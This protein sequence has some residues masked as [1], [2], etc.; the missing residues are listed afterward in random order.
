FGGV[1]SLTASQTWSLG[2]NRINVN[3]AIN[4][5]GNTLNISA[6]DA[7]SGILNFNSTT[8]LDSNVTIGTMDKVYSQGFSV[9]F[10]G[11]NNTNTSFSVFGGTANIASMGN[12]TGAS[13]IGKNSAYV[14]STSTLNYTGA[15]ATSDKG[16]TRDTNGGTTATDTSINVITA[17]ETLTMS[18]NLTPTTAFPTTVGGWK[19]GG[20]GNLALS[21]NI[22]NG[23]STTVTKIGAGTLTLSG[24][25]TYTGGTTVSAGTLQVGTADAGSTGPGTVQ[26]QSGATLLGTGTVQTGAF[27]AASGAAIQ[28]GDGTGTGDFGTLS[29][30]TTSGS[31]N[32][33][34]QSGSNTTLGLKPAGSG[35]TLSFNGSSAGTLNFNGNLAV[36][37]PGYTPAGV[38]VFNLLDWTNISTTVFDSRY[39]AA[40]YGGLLLGNGDDGLGFDLPD[41]SGSGYGWDIS[42]FTTDGTIATVAIPEP[43][44]AALLLLGLASLLPR[45]RPARG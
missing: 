37:A 25:N 21:G 45:R 3:G 29:F 30:I 39:N 7:A 17:G 15:T 24:T 19:F 36:T 38:E 23:T 8:T 31:G 35:D 40:S 18:G 5:A 44:E 26:V 14:R 33:D 4:T 6:K 41:I 34:L 28:A 11:T 42:K 13:S 12:L 20:A 10:N 32:F 27:T 9:T 43:G 16:I 1:V 22:T 2:V